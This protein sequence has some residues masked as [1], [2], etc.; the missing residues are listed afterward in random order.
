MSE[1]YFSRKEK[2]LSGSNLKPLSRQEMFMSQSSEKEET[3]I[4]MENIFIAAQD[5]FTALIT[6]CVLGA[7]GLGRVY[8]SSL[9]ARTGGEVDLLS[10]EEEAKLEKCLEEHL[11]FKCLLGGFVQTPTSYGLF[12]DANEWIIQFTAPDYL[13]NGIWLGL[14]YE[15]R[16]Y[17]DT[18]SVV[19]TA[20]QL[21]EV[22]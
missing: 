21:Q 20:H 16:C 22:T 11:P 14:G 5:A 19:L 2:I 10:D 13:T 4:N 18:I 8:S 12:D 9:G 6:A 1:N 15:I 3:I 7:D 17:N